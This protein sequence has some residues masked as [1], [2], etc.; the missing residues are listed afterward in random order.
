MSCS[1]P[2]DLEGFNEKAWQSDKDGCQGLR[3][4]LKED[5]MSVK[6]QIKGL[7]NDEVITLLGKPNKTLLD[8]RNQK[9]FIYSLSPNQ[10]CSNHNPEISSE[11]SLRF[12]AIGLVY[13]VLVD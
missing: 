9:Y 5:L 8:K 13:E 7:N 6:E 10:S 1:P 11:L 12:S 4:K 2:I 3:L